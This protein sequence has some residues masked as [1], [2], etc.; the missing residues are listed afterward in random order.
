MKKKM[1]V[2]MCIFAF[3]GFFGNV[4]AGAES[5]NLAFEELRASDGSAENAIKNIR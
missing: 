4:N 2:A 3:F 5:R 1:L